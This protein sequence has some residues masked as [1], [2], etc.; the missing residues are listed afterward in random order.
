MLNP[1]KKL[2]L[3]VSPKDISMIQ[4]AFV[5]STIEQMKITNDEKIKLVQTFV[6]EEELPN[7]NGQQQDEFLGDHKINL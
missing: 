3:Q 7:L 6:E 1:N 5:L 2:K 4:T